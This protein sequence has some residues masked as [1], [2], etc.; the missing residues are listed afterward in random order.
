M[1]YDPNVGKV[2]LN[3][4]TILPVKVNESQQSNPTTPQEQVKNATQ[5]Y[6]ADNI[7]KTVEPPNLVAPSKA[8]LS[9]RI[10]GTDTPFPA[11]KPEAVNNHTSLG[12]NLEGKALNYSLAFGAQAVA[13]A[14]KKRTTPNQRKRSDQEGQKKQEQ[15]QDEQQQEEKKK[16]ENPEEPHAALSQVM[17]EANLP[18]DEINRINA[19]TKEMYDAADG[20]FGLIK[21]KCEKTQRFMWPKV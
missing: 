18:W 16:E 10:P 21:E 1:V 11:R 3:S 9:Q 5:K 12:K 13:S 6:A 20:M 14:L 19:N 2:T 8:T 4:A 17:N 15:Q 7:A